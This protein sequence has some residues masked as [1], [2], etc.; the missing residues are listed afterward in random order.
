MSTS[1][2]DRQTSRAAGRGSSMPGGGL[3]RVVAVASSRSRRSFFTGPIGLAK[4][5]RALPA[6]PLGSTRSTGPCSGCIEMTRSPACSSGTPASRDVARRSTCARARS[7]SGSPEPHDDHERR[8]CRG[9]R[10]ARGRRAPSSSSGADAARRGSA[11]SRRAR[12][13]TRSTRPRSAPHGERPSEHAAVALAPRRA[14]RSARCP[15]PRRA[16]GQRDRGRAAA[17]QRRASWI[18]RAEVG[19]VRPRRAGVRAW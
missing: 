8:P 9:C 4:R 5:S 15:A 12:P 18:R 1:P 3:Q 7:S 11:W 2:A 17:E 14:A 16:A 10:R 6:G 13:A 19:G